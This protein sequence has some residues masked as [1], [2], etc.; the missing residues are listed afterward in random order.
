[1][2]LLNFLSDFPSFSVLFWPLLVLI[3]GLILI[4]KKEDF[5]RNLNSRLK[6]FVWKVRYNIEG[7]ISPKK[8]GYLTSLSLKKAIFLVSQRNIAVG[9]K[10]NFS[11]VAN[12][13]SKGPKTQFRGKVSK[14]KK[15]GK[16]KDKFMVTVKLLED[17]EQYSQ[18]L[19][20]K[21]LLD[22]AS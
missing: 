2:N 12:R 13:G 15:S 10:L 4:R 7:E 22:T 19:I 8:T 21:Y 9:T 1:M 17:Q 18:A 5:K 6:N 11:V 14:I 16:N 20:K 3:I